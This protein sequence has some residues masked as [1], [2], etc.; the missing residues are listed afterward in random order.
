MANFPDLDFI[1]GILQGEPA[2]YHQGLTHSLGMALIVSLVAA[3]VF[4][5]EGMAVRSTFL[6]C[7]ICYASHLVLDFFG[8][9]GRLPYG[10]PLFWPVVNQY[11]I[12]PIPIFLGVSHAGE[13]N[14]SIQQW[15]RGILTLHNIAAM[16]VEILL[17]GPFVFLRTLVRPTSRTRAPE[18]AD[19]LP[20]S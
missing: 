6:L 7:L 17:I 20:E 19:S 5:V 11:F 1:P 14:A 10:I 12:S 18:S 13:T 15:I 2:L 8:P 9:D 4:R 16:A 3:A